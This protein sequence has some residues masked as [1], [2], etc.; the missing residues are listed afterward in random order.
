MIKIFCGGRGGDTFKPPPPPTNN[1]CLYPS[2]IL[3]YFWKDPVTTSPTS[4]TPLQA[5]F[6]ATPLPIHHPFLPSKNF[7][8]TQGVSAHNLKSVLQEF[9][10]FLTGVMMFRWNVNF[11]SLS[12]AGATGILDVV[13]LRLLIFLPF[14]S[15]SLWIFLDQ[16]PLKNKYPPFSTSSIPS[17]AMTIPL[18]MALIMD[19]LIDASFSWNDFTVSIV[20]FIRSSGRS[21]GRPRFSLHFLFWKVPTRKTVPC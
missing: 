12:K 7:D 3:R 5:S 6:T 9:F 21:F 11:S 15:I 2:P 13:A 16:L 17:L 18:T 19:Q 10:C 8:R 1:F 14:R 20:F 4:T